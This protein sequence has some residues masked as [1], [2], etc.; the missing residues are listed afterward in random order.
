MVGKI[1]GLAEVP[2]LPVAHEMH[3]VR[4]FWYET[5]GSAQRYDG[6]S[7]CHGADG[8][9]PV[10]LGRATD[11][12]RRPEL[13]GIQKLATSKRGEQPFACGFYQDEGA[14]PVVL[15]SCPLSSRLQNTATEG[16]CCD[17]VL[18]KSP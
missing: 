9:S 15:S 11:Q 1:V 16:P 10:Q 6:E 12:A 18:S 4:V 5:D 14:R 17:D 2:R 7:E 13:E 8:K 3:A